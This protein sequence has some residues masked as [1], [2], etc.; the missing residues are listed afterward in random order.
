MPKPCHCNRWGTGTCAPQSKEPQSKEMNTKLE[1]M[2]AERNKQ[3]GMWSQPTNDPKHTQVKG[4][5][6]D[7]KP[8]G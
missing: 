5:Q 2:M 8:R 6:T 1:Q 3:D 4:L 7:V